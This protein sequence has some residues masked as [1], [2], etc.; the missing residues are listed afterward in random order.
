M[1]C[2]KDVAPLALGMAMIHAPGGVGNFR[3][4]TGH[5]DGKTEPA[6]Q[7]KDCDFVPD[8]SDNRERLFAGNGLLLTLNRFI[9]LYL[10]LTRPDGHRVAVVGMVMV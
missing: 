8:K 5:Q 10:G 3:M 2:Y 1:G 6:S 4:R 9:F 7:A